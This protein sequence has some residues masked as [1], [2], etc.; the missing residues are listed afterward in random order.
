MKK[1]MPLFG[2]LLPLTSVH[3]QSNVTIYGIIDSAVTVAR[4]GNGKGKTFGLDSGVS[5]GSRLGFRGT[6][7]LGGG[8]RAN[9]L[10]ENGF[11]SDTGGL[12]QGGLLFGRQAWVGVS[13]TSGWAVTAGRQYSPMNIALVTADPGGQTYWGNTQVAGNGSFQSPNAVAGDG[14]H[15]AT[16]RINNSVMGTWNT[17]GLVLR[18]MVAAGD[19]N[20]IG[21]GRLLGGSATYAAGPWMATASMTRFRQYARDIPLGASADWQEEAMVGGA[22]DF[23]VA[24]VFT[25]YYRFNP[26]EANKVVLPTTVAS[27]ATYWLGTRIPLG[28]NTL[29]AQAFRTRFD[30]NGERGYGTTLG[31]TL[32]HP[33]SKRTVLYTSY[34][35]I[36][37]NSRSAAVLW[38]GTAAQNFAGE[39]GASPKALSFGVRH[40][41]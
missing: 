32:E 27:T 22:Y 2:L 30:Y 24:R 19:E 31:M 34:G 25:G 23:G 1:L 4:P 11:S 5:N 10:L 13:S 28:A 40:A 17:G 33:L 37:N 36:T 38:A 41:F 3:G 7:D 6:E 16:G 20:A 39:R 8:L 18:A 14:G 21:S 29:I 12:Q 26:S 15:Q 9:F 35:Q